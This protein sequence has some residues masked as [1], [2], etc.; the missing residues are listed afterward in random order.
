VHF[1][2]DCGRRLGNPND[3]CLSCRT[4]GPY[5]CDIYYPTKW[6]DHSLPF[7][8]N[9]IRAKQGSKEAANYLCE[10]MYDYLLQHESLIDDVEIIVPVPN[11]KRVLKDATLIAEEFAKIIRERVREN[12]HSRNIILERVAKSDPYLKTSSKQ[13]KLHSSLQDYKVNEKLKKYML[14]NGV[15]NPLKDKKILLIDDIIT[16]GIT[17]GVCANLLLQLGAKRVIMFCAGRTYGA[18][19]SYFVPSFSF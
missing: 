17:I 11:Q 12:I 16:H 6:E 4:E 7:S 3:I 10:K 8:K 9:I 5:S 14:K 1:C 18:S 19:Q 13:D 15:K 2:D